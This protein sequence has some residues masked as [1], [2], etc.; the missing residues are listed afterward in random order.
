M[1]NHN[2]MSEPCTVVPGAQTHGD[3]LTETQPPGDEDQ[4]QGDS[5]EDIYDHNGY[6]CG[7]S[8]SQ[9]PG[10]GFLL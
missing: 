8:S 4:S 5:A 1:E 3:F 10:Q 9:P 2:K 7:Q 6:T